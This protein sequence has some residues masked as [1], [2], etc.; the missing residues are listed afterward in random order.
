MDSTFSVSVTSEHNV[1][2]VRYNRPLLLHKGLCVE[3]VAARIKLRSG[4]ESTGQICMMLER[5]KGLSFC[6]SQQ[7]LCILYPESD[8]IF[9]NLCGTTCRHKEG[10]STTTPR[11]IWRGMEDTMFPVWL[12]RPIGVSMSCAVFH[13]I[14]VHVTWKRESITWFHFFTSTMSYLC[15]ILLDPRLTLFGEKKLYFSLA[16]MFCI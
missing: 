15:G 1:Q 14:T 11:S 7:R 9:R 12:R 10:F 2:S 16:H 5:T 4:Q 13:S 8:L 3:M 6:W